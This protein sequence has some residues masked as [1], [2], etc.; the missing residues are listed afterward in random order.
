MHKKAEIAI[1]ILAVALAL[2]IGL[3]I[4]TGNTSEDESAA[5]APTAQPIQ[6][7][8]TAEVQPA[9]D[10]DAAAETADSMADT[11]EAQ[12]DMYEGAIA[13]L[14]EEEIAALALAEENVHA[15]EDAEDAED[16]NR[17]SVD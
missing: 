11:D 2:V 13:G 7:E 8:E 1:A 5:A 16:P 14:T 15:G 9:Q 4:I 12:D 3:L 10:A 17:G 6:P